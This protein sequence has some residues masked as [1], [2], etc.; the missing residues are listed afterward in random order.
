MDNDE[1]VQGF[2]SKRGY[3]FKKDVHLYILRKKHTSL[4]ISTGDECFFREGDYVTKE[5]RVEKEI[6]YIKNFRDK[7]KFL[8]LIKIRDIKNI[9][10]ILKEDIIEKFRLSGY[11][12]TKNDRIVQYIGYSFKKSEVGYV[13]QGDG[14]VNVGST[15]CTKCYC[16]NTPPTGPTYHVVL[17][18]KTLGFSFEGYMTSHY[19][20]GTQQR[21]SYNKYGVDY[22]PN[23]DAYYTHQNERYECTEHYG[24]GDE[25]FT[26]GINSDNGYFESF[27]DSWKSYYD[28]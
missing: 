16:C 8:F 3:Q 28:F 25:D 26:P 19:P 22:S 23:Y 7:G 1:I 14:P 2:S 27:H 17:T 9:D 5:D 11:T 21:E 10:L 20:N 13:S 24:G 15:S 18:K 12:K 6:K 4:V